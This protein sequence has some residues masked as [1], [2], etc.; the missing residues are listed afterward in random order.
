MFFKGLQY[1]ADHGIGFDYKISIVSS[2]G[3][4]MK[5]LIR[6]DW[7]VGGVKGKIG[8]KG[9]IFPLS[10]NPVH[11]LLG[12]GGQN[13]VGVPTFSHRSCPEAASSRERSGLDHGFSGNGHET[14][15]L[16]PA[17]RREVN[18]SIPKVVIKTLIEWAVREAFCPVVRLCP[19]ISAFGIWL[20]DGIE[21]PA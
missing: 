5:F 3:F 19:R 13:F 20:T 7:V 17:V 10:G 18:S 4:S 2:F 9:L 16:D 1:F 14:V 21:V 6:D 11:G 15:S 8:E 12:N